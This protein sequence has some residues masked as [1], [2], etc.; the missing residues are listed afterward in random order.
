MSEHE[1]VALISVAAFLY[2]R[3][4]DIHLKMLVFIGLKI[5]ILVRELHISKK[6]YKLFF[7]IGIHYD[8]IIFVGAK[9]PRR[10][11]GESYNG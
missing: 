9:E 4:Q 1:A 8:K 6:I 7:T 3:F 10:Y 5:I 2:A 11:I